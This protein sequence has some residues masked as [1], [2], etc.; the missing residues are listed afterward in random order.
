MKL[1][2]LVL[3]LKNKIQVRHNLQSDTLTKVCSLLVYETVRCGHHTR[4][5]C[6]DVP[7]CDGIDEGVHI[8]HDYRG[9]E[10]VRVS[11]HRAGAEVVPL[12]AHALLF[13]LR[14]I[15]TAEAKGHRRQKTLRKDV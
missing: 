6:F 4:K 2:C 7:G 12:N 15:L 13:I 9:S 8:K 11:L 10:V 5:N 1:L 3:S 14:E